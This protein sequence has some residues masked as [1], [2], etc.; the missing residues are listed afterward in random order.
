MSQIRIELDNGKYTYIFDSKE[1]KALRHGEEW[2]NLAGDNLVL[3]MGFKIEELQDRIAEL[4]AEN[5]MMQNAM[6]SAV[7][8]HNAL[9]EVK[10]D[11]VHEMNMCLLQIKSEN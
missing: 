1:H 6:Q 11:T 10:K 7:F 2:R 8:D 5:K 9:G 3:H 4:E